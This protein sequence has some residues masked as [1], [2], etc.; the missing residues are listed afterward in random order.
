M[1]KGL[2]ET[3]KNLN[4][5]LNNVANCKRARKLRRNLLLIGIPLILIAIAGIIYCL[6]TFV[7]VG[8]NNV[9]NISSIKNFD[10]NKITV[11]KLNVENKQK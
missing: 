2:H 1:F 8:L 5:D 6:Y 10:I 4:S 3:I 11:Y 9:K 7:N